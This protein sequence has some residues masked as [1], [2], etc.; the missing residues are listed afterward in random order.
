MEYTVKIFPD[1][2][3]EG[4][5]IA[6][7]DELKGCSAFGKTPE[8]ALQEI[9]TAMKLWIEAAK[10]HGKPIPKPKNPK[11]NE[12]KKRFNVLFP[13]S[14]LKNVDEYRGKHGMK[15]SELLAA[16]AEQFISSTH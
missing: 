11:A 1:P 2:E 8:E 12:Q 16:A 3:G 9:E 6:E 13:E 15:R 14:L 10:K 5:Y 4:D 7:I